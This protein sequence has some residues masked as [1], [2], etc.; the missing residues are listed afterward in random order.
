[1]RWSLRWRSIARCFGRHR[2]LMRTWGPVAAIG[3]ALPMSISRSAFVTMSV[4][5][6]VLIPTWPLAIRRRAL[7]VVLGVVVTLQLAAPRMLG[8]LTG[9]FSNA[10]SDPSIEGRTED[11]VIVSRYIVD[12][13]L[14][15][16]GFF[17]FLPE[18]YTFLDNQYLMSLIDSGVVGAAALVALFVVGMGTARGARARS[19]DPAVRDLG[20]AL[21]ASLAGTMIAFGTFDALSFPMV[22]ATTFLLV[23][24]AGALWRLVP[25]GSGP[26]VEG[27][28]LR[29]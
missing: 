4:G 7:H 15:G 27:F 8:A 22:A 23:G 26:D 25:N 13:P 9:L 28:Q 16:R 5:L 29:R 10:G 20:Q 2:S 18:R 1:M 14:F 21:A 24:L 6:L 11:Y 19:D 12:A 17:T 3:L